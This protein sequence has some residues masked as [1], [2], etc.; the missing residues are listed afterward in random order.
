M[1]SRWAGGAVALAAL[2]VA[3]AAEAAE[4]G[5]LGGGEDLSIPVWRILAAF[6]LC[7]ALAFAAILVL[8]RR[9]P[10]APLPSFPR[11]PVRARRIEV[12]ETRRLSP[13]ADISL[14]RENGRE[15][16][17]LLSAGGGQVLRAGTA[18]LLEPASHEQ[19]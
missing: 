4:P 5:G 7:V 17:L 19:P 2:T 8:R 11:L 18:E 13:H 16:L 15:Y 3:A 10:G 6:L 14:V 1:T 12:L 9:R